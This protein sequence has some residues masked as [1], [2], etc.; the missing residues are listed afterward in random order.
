[1]TDASRYGVGI[2]MP[3][4]MGST[5]LVQVEDADLL[6]DAVRMTLAIH[7]GELGYDTTKGCRLRELKH[8]HFPP[9]EA[10]SVART[11]AGEVLAREE[12]AIQPI[13]AVAEQDGSTLR[14]SISYRETRYRGTDGPRTATLEV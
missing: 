2:A 10:S 11:L 1:M 3:L 14:I 4:T 8:R 6:A 9:T 13:S 5:D 7:K 12:Q